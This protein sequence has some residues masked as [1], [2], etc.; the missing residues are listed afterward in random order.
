MEFVSSTVSAQVSVFATEVPAL[1]T[2]TA[3]AALLTQAH[4]SAQPAPKA[5]P[6]PRDT[7]L[8]TARMTRLLTRWEM[9]DAIM[10]QSAQANV[11]AQ[12]EFA[13]APINVSAALLT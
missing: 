11:T 5:L 7:A 8:H 3:S 1:A 10:I 9:A 12:T 2:I 6:P 13:Q 4:F